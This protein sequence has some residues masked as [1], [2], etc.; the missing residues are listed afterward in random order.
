V[1]LGEECVPSWAV[2]VGVMLLQITEAENSVSLEE[3]W[4]T[5][6]FGPCILGL[7]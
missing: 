3:V 2:K 1:E 7:G 6:T 4:G 5:V